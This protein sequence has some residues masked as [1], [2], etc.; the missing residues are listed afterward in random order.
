VIAAAA[1]TITDAGVRTALSRAAW[2]AWLRADLASLAARMPDNPARPFRDADP[3]RLAA[4]QAHD[5]EPLFAAVAD[6][7]FETDHTDVDHVVASVLAA[8]RSAGTST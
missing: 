6:A 7:A 2:V 1:S 3:A 8:F 5:R 4:E